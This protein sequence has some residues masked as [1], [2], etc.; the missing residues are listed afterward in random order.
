MGI[1]NS[2]ILDVGP[3]H[4]TFR[5]KGQQTTTV[6]PVEFLRRFVQHVLPDGFHKIRHAGLYASARPGGLLERA[7][8]LLPV[9]KPH[10]DAPPVVTDAPRTCAHCG[11]MIMRYPLSAMP[12][13]PPLETAC[14]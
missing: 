6:H 4:V 11:G 12:R 10:K 13:A 14:V 7:R 8:A 1:A 3:E 9:P 2:R 5:T